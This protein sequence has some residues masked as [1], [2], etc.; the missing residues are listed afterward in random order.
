M[1]D[2]K[3]TS[4]LSSS[5]R[6]GVDYDKVYPSGGKLEDDFPRSPEKE[7]LPNFLVRKEMTKKTRRG[8]RKT[9]RREKVRRIRKVRKMGKT[10]GI[11]L[12]E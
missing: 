4:R 9:T 2:K 3:V 7:P 1:S 8:M 10:R 6:E 5:I 12:R 11:N